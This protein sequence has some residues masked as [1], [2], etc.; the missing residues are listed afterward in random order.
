[1]TILHHTGFDV[2]DHLLRGWTVSDSATWMCRTTNG[3]TP[4]GA[5]RS[6]FCGSGV[7][8]DPVNG[9]Y[10]SGPQSPA[11]RLVSGSTG[12]N[13]M[14]FWY[15]RSAMSYSQPT[16]DALIA[17]FGYQTN[18]GTPQMDSG[19]YVQAGDGSLR[20][21][22][23]GIVMATASQP[24]PQN[25]WVFVEIGCKIDSTVGRFVV[26]I[27]GVTV[28]DYSGDTNYSSNTYTS[29]AGNYVYLGN[30]GWFGQW[31]DDLYVCS[32]AGTVNNN[33]L[34][35]VRVQTLRPSGAGFDTQMITTA[36]NVQHF[37]NVNE[38]PYDPTHFNADVTVGH[39]DTYAMDDLV[40][41]TTGVKAV[42]AGFI[43]QLSAAGS[44]GM[45]SC[46]RI[47]STLY[48]NPGK[49][50][51]ATAGAFTDL[52]ETSPATSAA[53]TVAELNALEAGA[54]VA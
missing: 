17:G 50:L 38:S 8:L 28:L 7:V 12:M 34:G 23:S 2:G 19:L 37:A 15:R 5:G 41:G 16:T 54:E 25:A 52:L 29:A 53:W 32:D 44:G 31:F 42:N 1:M 3:S 4:F 24:V 39:R 18:F 6:L 9:S 10:S 33:F 11:W 51:A 36:G 48:Y 21:I 43:G 22:R 14:G 49:T 47:G 27:N 40:T 46:E 45:R 30:P 35:P 20:A 13:Y 26:R